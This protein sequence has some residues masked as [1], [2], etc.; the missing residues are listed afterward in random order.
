MAGSSVANYLPAVTLA[1]K[2]RGLT[3]PSVSSVDVKL[4]LAGIK[5]VGLQST[6]VC[7]PITIHILLCMYNCLNFRLNCHVMFW[8]ICLLL[9]G[10]LLRVSHVVQSPHTLEVPYLIWGKRGLIIRVR[11]SKTSRDSR[12]IPMAGLRDI[13]LYLCYWLKKWLSEI[14]QTGV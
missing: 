4:T 8:S 13:R 11:S 7:D 5:R 3:P 10:S 6:C 12:D 2:L 9:L 14:C 1:H